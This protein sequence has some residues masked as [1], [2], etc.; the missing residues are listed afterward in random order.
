MS[1]IMYSREILPARK[2]TSIAAMLASLWIFGVSGTAN[3]ARPIVE[4][5][6]VKQGEVFPWPLVVIEGDDIPTQDEIDSTI[7]KNGRKLKRKKLKEKR[8]T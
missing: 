5:A 6:T 4:F 7:K 3:A 1:H 2:I 8:L